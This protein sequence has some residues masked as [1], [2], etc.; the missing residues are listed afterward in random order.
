MFVLH[1]R[2]KV[3]VQ[4]PH[5]RF[6]LNTVRSGFFVQLECVNSTFKFVGLKS[7]PNPN[8]V[9]F[10]PKPYQIMSTALSQQE[11]KHSVQRNYFFLT[12]LIST[13]IQATGLESFH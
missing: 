11:I 4:P 8:Q 12:C 6:N 2:D 3:A 5:L 13:L 7:P 9:V 1:I 10:V